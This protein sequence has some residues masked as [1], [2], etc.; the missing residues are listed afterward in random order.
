MEDFE[1]Q[2]FGQKFIDKKKSVQ[3]LFTPKNFA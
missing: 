2:F 1:P 3:Q